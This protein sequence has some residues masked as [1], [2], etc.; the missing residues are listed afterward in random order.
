LFEINGLL[1]GGVGKAEETSLFQIYAST[2]RIAAATESAV[3]EFLSEFSAW[4]K[5]KI[6]KADLENSYLLGVENVVFY[7]HGW[8]VTRIST[9]EAIGAGMDFALAALHLGHTPKE[10]VQVA[11]EL[12]VFCEGPIQELSRQFDKE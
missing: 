7:I 9:F 6:D 5:K 4:K 1:V 10:A 11:T 12:S 3:L 8:Y 2:H